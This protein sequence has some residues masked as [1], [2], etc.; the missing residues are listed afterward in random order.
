ML[1]EDNTDTGAEAIKI[2][3]RSMDPTNVSDELLERFK[4]VP[5]ATVWSAVCTDLGV[6]KP[7]MEN[8]MP[9][10]PGKRLAARA[11]TLRFLPPRMDKDAETKLGENSPEYIAMSRCGPGDVLVA[12]LMG[13]KFAAVAGDVKLLQLKMN[14]ADGVVTDGAIRDL[15]VL[16]NENYGLTVYACGR[17]PYGGRPWGEPAEENID[18]QCG[19]VLVR[20]GDVLVGDNDGVVVV[21]SWYAEECIEWVEHHEAIE[22]HIKEKVMREKVRPGKYYPPPKKTQTT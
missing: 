2:P 3:D 22:Q 13:Q 15:D 7:F 17:T 4:K 19:G 11:R 10:T 20:P 21:P 16:T 14:R 8:V 18:I 9:M 6:P 12:D 5:T 1:N